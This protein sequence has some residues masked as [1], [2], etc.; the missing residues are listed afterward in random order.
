MTRPAL[1][2]LIVALPLPVLAEAQTAEEALVA[3]VAAHGCTM[4][5][6]ESEEV[7]GGLGF[8]D[9]AFEVAFARLID[10]GTFVMGERGKSLTLTTGECAAEAPGTG[11]AA[12]APLPARAEMVAAFEAKDCRLGQQDYFDARD[13]S[14]LPREAWE[15]ALKAMMNDGAIRFEDGKNAVLTTGERCAGTEARMV[16]ADAAVTAEV[17]A[18]AAT[19]GCVLEPRDLDTPVAAGAFTRDQVDAVVVNLLAEGRIEVLDGG[20]IRF[21]GT[22]GCE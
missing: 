5:Q 12:A 17:V 1:A 8:S 3:A 2:A 21:E 6:S 7:F 22:E 16:E 10:E 9:E 18:L 15:E 11:D 14:D 13:A 20:D 19:L 4:R